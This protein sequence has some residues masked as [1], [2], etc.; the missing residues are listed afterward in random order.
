M[1][2][3]F[4]FVAPLHVIQ[5]FRLSLCLLPIRRLYECL[6]YFVHIVGKQWPEGCHS[7][8]IQPLRLPPLP[9]K[10]KTRRRRTKNRQLQ[11]LELSG[12]AHKN[13]NINKRISYLHNTAPG[14]YALL[15]L[16]FIDSC[17]RKNT[18]LLLCMTECVCVCIRMLCLPLCT[19][20]NDCSGPTSLISRFLRINCMCICMWVLIPAILSSFTYP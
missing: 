6:H 9:L 7:L 8:V 13:G 12:R 10:Q 15:T 18:C 16:V 5:S 11:F 17:V 20:S 19:A 2:S 1:R 14:F 3:L 4:V